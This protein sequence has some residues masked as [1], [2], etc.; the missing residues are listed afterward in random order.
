MDITIKIDAPELDDLLHL[1]ERYLN[2]QYQLH[3]ATAIQ[4]LNSKGVLLTML[5]LTDIQSCRLLIQPVD[6]KGNPAPIDGKPEWSLSDSN[7]LSLSVDDTGL[8]ATISA[9]G[10]LGQCQVNVSADADL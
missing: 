3:R 4:F 10:P 1:L 5:Q 9:Q 6:I 2:F 8:S 7:V